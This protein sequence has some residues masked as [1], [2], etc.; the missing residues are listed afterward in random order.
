MSV[1]VTASLRARTCEF[2]TEIEIE[3]GQD[4]RLFYYHLIPPVFETFHA[5]SKHIDLS[6]PSY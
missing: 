1:G 6:L 2:G 3:K 4:R 5:F